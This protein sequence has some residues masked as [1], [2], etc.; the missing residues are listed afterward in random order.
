MLIVFCF[1]V[2]HRISFQ[3]ASGKLKYKEEVWEG[4]EKLGDAILAVQKGQN[5]A[6]MVIKVADE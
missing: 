2:S 1:S 6:K 3:V 4:L 5:K